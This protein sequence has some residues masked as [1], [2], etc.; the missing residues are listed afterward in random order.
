MH[1]ESKEASSRLTRYL[2]PFHVWA[3]AFGCAVGWGSFVMPGTTFLPIAGPLGTAVGMFFGAVA[4]LIIGVNYHA[5]MNRF[6]GIGGTFSYAK[7]VFGYDHG[8]LSGWFL[9]LTYVSVLWANATALALIGRKLTGGFFQVGFHYQLAGFDIY[10]GEVLLSAAAIVIFGLFCARGKRAAANLQG[11]FA[12]ILL[13]GILASFGAGV[14]IA[15]GPEAFLPA[16]APG[17]SPFAEVFNIVALAPWAFIGFES[18][19]LSTEEFAFPVKRSLSIMAASL[20]ASFF[21]YT[22][23]TELAVTSIP[24]RFSRWPFYIEELGR[25]EGLEGLPTF[26]ATQA[27]LGTA[28][29]ALLGVTVLAGIITGLI[30][31]YIAASRLLYAMAEDDLLPKWFCVR[32]R[33]HTPSNAIFFIMAVSLVIPFFGRT[34]IGWIVDVT[35]IGATIAYGYTSAAAYVSAGETGDRRTRLTGAAGVVLSVVF[36]LFLLVPNLWSISALATESYLILAFWSILGFA[37]FRFIFKRDTTKRLGKSTVAWLGLLFLI[38]F[39]SLMWS[40]QATHAVMKDV[41]SDITDYY[42]L[43][44]RAQGIRREAIDRRYEQA[45]LE[46]QME[47]IQSSLL[48]NSIIQM[49]LIVFSLAIMFNV[50]SMMQR[51]E[52]QAELERVQAEKDSRAKTVFLS[53]MSHDIRTPMNAIIGYI[54]LA[55]KARAQ[56]DGCPRPPCEKGI[57]VQLDDF[58]Q[59]IETSS[60]HLLALINDVLEM[61]R[62]ESGR[63]ELEPAPMNIVKVLR[64]VHDMFATQMQTKNID[65]TVDTEG[66]KDCFVLCDENRLNRVLLNLLSNAYKFTPEDGSVA[67][68]LTEPAPAEDGFGSYELRVKDSGIGMSAEFAATVFESF[69]RERTSTVSGIQ[70]TGLGMAITKNIVDLMGGTIDVITAPGAGTEF[71][72]RLRLPLAP[73]AEAAAEEAAEEGAAAV[74]F[75]GKKLLLVDDLDVNREI[76]NMLLT[77]AGFVVEMAVNGKE[78]VEK[79]ETGDYDVILMD[80]Q[81]PV[82]NGYEATAAIR[83]FADEKRARVPILAMTANAF[84]E[85]V[86]AARDAGMDGHLAKPID[87][88]KM[89]ETLTE[90]LKRNP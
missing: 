2:S 34:A 81:M 63:L 40:R 8:F 26:F 33:S 84:S 24:A 36:S 43:R 19:S 4:M 12:V 89:M 49:A 79:A 75:D 28:G 15:P 41:V 67:L 66:V 38:F 61:S 5:M 65:F 6:P 37:F 46:E 7:R 70:G 53:N 14:S 76:A 74:A 82:M 35:T 51:R 9:V 80:I 3:L 88:P 22:L 60:H 42:A 71:V 48:K 68:R 59:K 78:A 52:K 29:L 55:K 20:V 23:L 73:E 44:Y 54:A 57:H 11:V 27:A 72:I 25:L 39:S 87:I 21:A 31:N 90:I 64:D 10:F 62:I 50:Y 16:F 45:H 69:T 47:T 32:N 13:L 83:A 85:D 18:I 56:C 1:T 86:Q 77:E 30:G 58:M 17:K